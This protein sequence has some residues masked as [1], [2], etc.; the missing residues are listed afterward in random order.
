[1]ND[2]FD[3]IDIILEILGTKTEIK[4]N[5]LYCQDKSNWETI[6]NLLYL[7]NKNYY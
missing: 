5:V 3:S 1:M 7:E 4:G 6:D 2:I